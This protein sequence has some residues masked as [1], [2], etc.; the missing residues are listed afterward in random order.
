M[1]IKLLSLWVEFNSL[2][3]LKFFYQLK[4]PMKSFQGAIVLM[5]RLIVLDRLIDFV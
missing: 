5:M 1:I 4:L 2:E 3:E